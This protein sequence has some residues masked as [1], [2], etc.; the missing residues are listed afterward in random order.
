MWVSSAFSWKRKRKYGAIILRRM[1]F[2]LLQQISVAWRNLFWSDVSI[3][4]KAKYY[5]SVD[6][7]IYE[8]IHIDLL[9]FIYLYLYIFI[10]II[11]NMIFTVRCDKE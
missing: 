2:W 8:V 9:N 5:V 7:V 11:W 4:I 10:F 6:V 1:F 3:Y